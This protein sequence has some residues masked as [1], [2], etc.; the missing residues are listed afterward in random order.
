MVRAEVVVAE[1]CI[2]ITIKLSLKY[3]HM[4]EAMSDG[5]SDNFDADGSE[6]GATVPKTLGQAKASSL[7]A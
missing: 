5:D 3:L 6:E 1:R 4:V 2:T 7:H